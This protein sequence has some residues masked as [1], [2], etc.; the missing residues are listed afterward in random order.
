MPELL[1]SGCVDA[2]EAGDWKLSRAELEEHM[3]ALRRY[4][5][6]LIGNRADADDLVQETLRRALTY[7]SDGRE[8]RN[9]RAYLMTMLHH[10]RVDHAKRVT[11][12]NDQIPLDELAMP[13]VPPSQLMRLE[14]R[15]LAAAIEMLPVDQREVLLL[16]GLEGMSYRETADLVGSPIGTV[17]SRLSRARM[18]LRHLLAQEDSDSTLPVGAVAPQHFAHAAR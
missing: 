18:A 6:A 8:I 14:C 16:V 13:S 11:R 3:R 4:A 9:P 1:S 10:V 12:Y 7:L 15:D 5:R 2:G 17:M